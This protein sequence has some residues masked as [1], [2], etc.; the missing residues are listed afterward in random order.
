[1]FP[2]GQRISLLRGEA[3]LTQWQLAS[4]AGYGL[5]TIGKIED[6]QPTGASTL[7]AVATVLSRRLKR[8]IGMPDLMRRATE[9]R[10][11]TCRHAVS[12]LIV[13]EAVKMLD[14]SAWRPASANGDGA[15]SNVVLSDHYRF[16]TPASVNEVLQFHYATAGPRID[17]EC[18]SQPERAQWRPLTGMDGHVEDEPHL[19]RAYRMRVPLERNA[20]GEVE[21]HNRLTY[22]DAFTNEEREWFH[23]HVVYPTESLTLIALLPEA[24]RCRSVQGLTKLHPAEPFGRAPEPP[25]VLKEGRLLVWHVTAPPQGST[26]QLEWE[27]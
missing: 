21:V 16:E 9:E 24:K 14:F 13:R 27:W 19:K 22:V 11:C 25:L 2:D 17:G 5:R 12:R 7:A 3:D 10:E 18:L 23:T 15:E 4:E 6:G 26:C 1:V 8:S 20:D